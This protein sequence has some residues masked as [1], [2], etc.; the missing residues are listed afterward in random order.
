MGHG[1]VV[2][3]AMFV[4]LLTFVL[5]TSAAVR[6]LEVEAPGTVRMEPGSVTLQRSYVRKDVQLLHV[7]N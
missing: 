6:R 7:A 3:N 1:W 2:E 4:L 5:F